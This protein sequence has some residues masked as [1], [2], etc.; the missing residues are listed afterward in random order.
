VA[1]FGDLRQDETIMGRQEK[2]PIWE[3]RQVDLAICN[4]LI[5]VLD[6]ETMIR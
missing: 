4:H 1:Y 2:Q 5:G 6:G 3:I